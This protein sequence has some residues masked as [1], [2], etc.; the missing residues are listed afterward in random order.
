MI[1]ALPEIS[2]SVFLWAGFIGSSAIVF[3]GVGYRVVLSAYRFL[4]SV[5]GET[6]R[7]YR[8]PVA[9]EYWYSDH[10]GVVR[11]SR[12]TDLSIFYAKLEVS[13]ESERVFFDSYLKDF[14][15]SGVRPL[16]LEE[17]EE[18]EKHQKPLS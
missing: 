4:L 3:S 11:I 12:V 17:K 2:S 14:L 16:T 6:K 7:R 5:Y 15:G 1:L 8:R 9:G 13:N 18:H 10:L